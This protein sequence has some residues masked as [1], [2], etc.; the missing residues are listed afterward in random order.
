MRIRWSDELWAF[1]HSKR[2]TRTVQTGSRNSAKSAAQRL[3]SLIREL[4]LPVS[5]SSNGQQV[6]MRK[7]RAA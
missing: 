7:E 3:R 6:V 2:K 4:R 1:A 5:V